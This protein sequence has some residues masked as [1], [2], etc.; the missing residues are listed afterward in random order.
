MT[1][2]YNNRIQLLLSRRYPMQT[3]PMLELLGVD[4]LYSDMGI[5]CCMV[6]HLLGA[7]ER[8]DLKALAQQGGRQG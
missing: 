3:H 2:V 7:I 6:A 8:C 1:Q 5:G 4:A